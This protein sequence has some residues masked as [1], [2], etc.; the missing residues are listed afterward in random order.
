VESLVKFE[1][2]KPETIE[3]RYFSLGIAFEPMLNIK[4][5]TMES[6][7]TIKGVVY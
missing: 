5:K 1:L 2:I 7:P 6:Y 4:S 3:L